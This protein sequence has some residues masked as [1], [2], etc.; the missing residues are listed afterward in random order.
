MTTAADTSGTTD[1]DPPPQHNREENYRKRARAAETELILAQARVSEMNRAEAERQAVQH[2]MADASDLWLNNIDLD[3]VLGDDK[4]V[5]A[6]KV[7]AAVGD[8]LARNPHLGRRGPVTPPA[9][10]ITGDGKPP[11]TQAAPTWQDAFTPD[12]G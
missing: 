5:D 8:L 11:G 6:A 1:D 7:D 2:G 12:T 4:L 10:N 9:S 3:D